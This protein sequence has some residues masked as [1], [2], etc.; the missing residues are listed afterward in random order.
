VDGHA[1]VVAG[2][3][4]RRAASSLSISSTRSWFNG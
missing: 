1:T 2:V 3:G 4:A